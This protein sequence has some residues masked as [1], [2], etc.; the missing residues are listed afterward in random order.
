[1][2]LL[3]MN[4][5]YKAEED[6]LGIKTLYYLPGKFMVYSWFGVSFNEENR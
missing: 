2:P 1:M 4:P 6:A 3:V 5:K